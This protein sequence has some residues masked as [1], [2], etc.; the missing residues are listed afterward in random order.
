MKITIKKSIIIVIGVVVCIMIGYT[1]A[2]L[3][4]ESKIINQ[5]G[6]MSI[7]ELQE[8]LEYEKT[9]NQ[10]LTEMLIISINEYNDLS[11]AVHKYENGLT[12]IIPSVIYPQKSKNLDQ[13][14]TVKL[15]QNLEGNQII[16]EGLLPISFYI[17]KG[18]L[19]VGDLEDIR[20][21]HVFSTMS[22]ERGF[23]E[24]IIN[25]PVDDPKWQAGNYTLSISSNSEYKQLQFTR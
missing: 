4:V 5:S 11:N 7:T 16:I 6:D 2:I 19:Y 24:Q 20:I 23:Y 13:E 22:N 9:R 21:V 15:S 10:E 3:F 12:Q 14:F 1:A 8:D 17:V 25:V 18:T